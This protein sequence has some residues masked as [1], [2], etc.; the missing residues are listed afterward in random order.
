[1]RTIQQVRKAVGD[2]RGSAMT[3]TALLCF[4]IYAPILMMTLIL[5]DVTLERQQAQIAAAYLAW[6]PE[7][8]S[9]D[10]LRAKFF[11]DS[12]RELG[13]RSTYTVEDSTD[14][15]QSAPNYVA[16]M[17]QGGGS[18][19]NVWQKLVV[20]AYGEG[21]SHL[22][23][24]TTG[25]TPQ[26]V[27]VVDFRADS[28]AQYLTDNQI[29]VLP[30]GRQT[31][32]VG[33]PEGANVAFNWSPPSQRAL[34]ATALLNHEWSLNAPSPLIEPRADVE[35]WH[36]S[37]FFDD[38]NRYS[39]AGRTY[40]F[41]LPKSGDGKTG[42]RMKPGTPVD[43]EKGGRDLVGRVWL[44]NPLSKPSAANVR[45]QIYQISPDLFAKQT[46]GGVYITI[47]DMV[48]PLSTAGDTPDA[49]RPFI[50]VQPGDPRSQTGG[51]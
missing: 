50:F 28:D 8:V 30:G 45:E 22:Q 24:D 15:E 27:S 6:T 44:F 7:S 43:G 34:A 1:M 26:L 19:E 47:R 11:A 10:Q 39:Y 5:G 20:M 33:V 3:E 25:P 21:F 31:R 35:L 29:V 36:T 49:Q 16:Q 32:F 4:F 14:E 9:T 2:E 48:R 17:P 23:W 38:L 42:I 37:V 18:L 40:D 12:G 51:P 41:D 46:A 13:T